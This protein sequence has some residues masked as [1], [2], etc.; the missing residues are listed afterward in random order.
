MSLYL[1]Q[2]PN[3]R[4]TLRIAL[5][6]GALSYTVMKDGVEAAAAAPIGAVLST[7]D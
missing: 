7:A 5:E 3:G 6:G 4:F 2:S 1:L